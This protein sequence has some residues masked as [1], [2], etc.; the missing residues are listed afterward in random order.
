MHPS[1]FVGRVRATLLLALASTLVL[2]LPL[3]AAPVTQ[4]SAEAGPLVA[5]DAAQRQLQIKTFPAAAVS[6]FSFPTI[7]PI[8]L[9][10]LREYNSGDGAKRLQIGVERGLADETQLKASP[11]LSWVRSAQGQQITRLSMRSPGAAALRVGLLIQQLPEGAQLR[12]VGDGQSASVVDPVT[13]AQIK[14]L[15][16]PVYWTPVTEG[17]R[18]TLE[19]SLP[20]Q[21]DASQVQLTV[22]GVAH[23]YA[24]PYGSL[25]GLKIGESEFCEIDANCI[26]NPSTAYLNA[27]NAVAR[28]S[29][30]DAGS[31]YVCTGTLMNDTVAGTFI[32]YFF[33]AHHCIST[34]TAANTLNTFWFM[35]STS[36]GS[37]VASSRVQLA[38]G[39]TLLYN[40]DTTDALLLRLNSAPPNGAIFA[41]WDANQVSAGSPFTVIHHPAGDVKKV[42][43]GQ[44]TGIGTFNGSGSFVNVGYTT[45]TTEGGSSGAGLLIF[46]NGQYYVRGGLKGGSAS[47]ANTGNLNNPGN[48]D[49]YSRFD[50]AF[51]GMQ[52][53]LAP[54]QQQ[55]QLTVVKGGAGSGT[56]TS[57]PAGINCGAT[58][59]AS[60][61]SGTQIVLTASAAGGSAFSSWSGCDATNGNT[62]TVA[63]SASRSV[64]ANFSSSGGGGSTLA[65]GVPVGGLSATVGSALLYTVV[66]PS[67]AQ[68][69]VI[70]TSGG[71]G[72]ADL[73][74][75]LGSAPTTSTYDCRSWA[76]G[77][78]EQCTFA[79]PAAGTYY[80]LINAFESFSGVSLVA[81]WQVAGGGGTDEPGY[82]GLLLPIPNPPFANCPAG[83]FVA[84][85]DDG[86][87]AGLQAGTF[88]LALEIKPPGTQRLDGGLNFGG[89]VDGSQVAFAGFN[90]VNAANELQRLTL[91]L[92]G[93]PAS[94][95]N[96]S[97]PVRI[98][99]I[100]QPAPGVNELVLETIATLTLAQQV[101]RTIDLTPAYYV[102]TVAPEGPAAV[103]GG[104][105]DGQ[106]FVALGTQFINRPGGGFSSGVVIGGYHA[107]HPFGG[108]SAFAAVCLGTQH[109]SDARVYSAPTYGAGGARDLRLRL[110]DDQQ[111][112]VYTSSGNAP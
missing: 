22:Q 101:V 33:S 23:L 73:Y 36:C 99:V 88:G 43:Q 96:G 51:A 50:V 19:L 13:T 27:K 84:T 30:Q 2:S 97:L 94:S 58:C 31:S 18:Q 40:S 53:Y 64:T 110:L 28:M 38:G 17:D 42:S 90:F 104:A 91:T 5:A 11:E 7:A 56:V 66:I 85:V 76:L 100:R 60:F 24:S 35:E 32:P 26:S 59:S 4:V 98:K 87:G 62:C 45:A 1:S 54:A 49:S 21:A 68:N 34:Q 69:L 29:F 81:S 109:V 112:V 74:V 37:G 47:C 9:Q 8:R 10:K 79:A 65:N 14:A 15:A 70:S 102:V 57:N 72:D 46:S 107:V 80:V 55:P 108:V 63:L 3:S 39:A 48:T 52:Q 6:E 67:G 92:L 111:R 106:V 77:P 12:F 89:L 71:S 103:P 16:A 75:R 44:V 82:T 95:Q 83:Y 105:A 25:K 78:A 41:G 61:A 20:A 86:P 93:N